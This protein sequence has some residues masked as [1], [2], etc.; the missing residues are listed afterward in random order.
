[1]KP[2]AIVSFQTPPYTNFSVTAGHNGMPDKGK[3]Q[4]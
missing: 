2:L 3:T 1:M 4:K